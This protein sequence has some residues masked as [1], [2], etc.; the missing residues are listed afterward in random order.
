MNVFLVEFDE[1]KLISV[2]LKLLQ[3]IADNGSDYQPCDFL[4]LSEVN[5]YIMNRFIEL[6]LES[7]FSVF[8]HDPILPVRLTSLQFV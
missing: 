1:E 4:R 7:P 2:N 5:H 3:R 6:F 8:L